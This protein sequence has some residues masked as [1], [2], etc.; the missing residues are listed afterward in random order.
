M[1]STYCFI[2]AH[3]LLISWNVSRQH[4]NSERAHRLGCRYSSVEP[5]STSKEGH[6]QS[7][8]LPFQCSIAHFT[9]RPT[10]SFIIATIHCCATLNIFIHVTQQ[11]T[12]NA[13]S[14]HYVVNISLFKRVRK[15]AKSFVM[16]IFPSVS[17]HETTRLPM[18]G[19]MKFNI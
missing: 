10:L 3:F 16:S 2:S 13:L 18:D 9:S 12:Q 7:N 6:H 8:I 11:N 1:F 19:L 15:I 5:N 4:K 14:L 17:P